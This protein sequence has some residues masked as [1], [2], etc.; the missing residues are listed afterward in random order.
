MKKV[1]N[2]VGAII[3]NDSGEIL[4]ALRSAKMNY[5]NL[6]E[7]PGGKIEV[8]E[9][10]CQAIVREIKE[11]LNCEIEFIKKYHSNLYEEAEIVINLTTL[12][13]KLIAG[14]PI[15]YE[16]AKLIW[17]SKDNL[18]S[19]NWAPADLPTVELLTQEKHNRKC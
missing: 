15:A 11:E 12:N 19:L 10:Y 13:C 9:D 6:W 8:G 3:A 17:L 7:L 5:G 18:S 14:E 16:H 4:C 1:I 2:V